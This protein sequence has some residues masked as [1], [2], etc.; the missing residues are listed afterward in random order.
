MIG[1]SKP[2]FDMSEGHVELQIIE[3]LKSG[4]IL[5]LECSYANILKS[6]QTDLL[7]NTLNHKQNGTNLRTK[8]C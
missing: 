6:G 3:D 4:S 7:I 1:K 2:A 5:T 8:K